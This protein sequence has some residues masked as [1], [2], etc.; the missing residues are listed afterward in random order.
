LDICLRRKVERTEILV[1]RCLGDVWLGFH[2]KPQLVEVFEANV[3][4][5]HS[6]DQMIAHGGGQPSPSLDLHSSALVLVAKHEAAQLVSQLLDLFR[7]VGGAEAFRQLEECFLFLL[8]GFDSL[9]DEFHQHAIIAESALPG[10]GLDLPCD[11]GRQGHTSPD[12]LCARGFCVSSFCSWH[13]D[14]RI[15]HFGAS[16][17]ATAAAS[18]GNAEGWATRRS[19]ILSGTRLG[20]R[21]DRK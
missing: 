20:N 17:I 4:V 12:M 14:T 5:A 1:P 3:A 18:T 21:E 6:L 13:G 16:C 2:P 11:L 9:L 8:L 19:V 7:V 15:H 10:Q